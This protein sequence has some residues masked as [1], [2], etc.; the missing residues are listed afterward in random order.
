MTLLVIF[1]SKLKNEIN[2]KKL[3]NCIIQIYFINLDL[4]EIQ[5]WK[6]NFSV[7]FLFCEKSFSNRAT[8]KKNQFLIFDHSKFLV[9]DDK[10]IVI[11]N[12]S[13]FGLLYQT[14]PLRL[15]SPLSP[16]CFT[17]QELYQI[18]VKINLLRIRN[19]DWFILLN[20]NIFCSV[21]S[22]LMNHYCRSRLFL[23]KPT[24]NYYI[25]I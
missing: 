4:I 11:N 24:C 2:N 12:E 21:Q 6:L 25:Y 19:V 10:H 3:F 17:P 5:S 14:S 13:P 9:I 8:H 20:V 7:E 18:K 22:S 15:F 1:W 16:W 23:P